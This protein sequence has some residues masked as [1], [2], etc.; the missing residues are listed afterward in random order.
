MCS[1]PRVNE[2]VLWE[3]GGSDLSVPYGE[4][5]PGI[6]GRC[7]TEDVKGPLRCGSPGITLCSCGPYSWVLRVPYEG[8]RIA[9][10]CVTEDV[11][12]SLRCGS[13]GITLC[14]CG[15]Y[16]WGLRV[17]YERK[18]IT[19]GCVTEDVAGSLRC[20]SDGIA[21]CGCSSYCGG[22]IVP[23][24]EE[25]PERPGRWVTVDGPQPLR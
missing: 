10:G 15:P 22:L 8:K 19:D 12:G 18:Q 7:V 9:D 2:I 4:K 25:R 6:T 17:P 21:L 23:N 24:G 16:S 3:L 11:A 1:C 5:R 14:S 13:P 20:G